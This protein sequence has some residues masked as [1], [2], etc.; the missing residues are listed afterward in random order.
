MRS[1][2]N[3]YRGIKDKRGKKRA[4]VNMMSLK[5]VTNSAKVT[6]CVLTYI[7]F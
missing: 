2:I 1:F 7:V 5:P 6:H 3:A 4:G